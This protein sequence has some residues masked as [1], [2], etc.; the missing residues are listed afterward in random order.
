MVK[1]IIIDKIIGFISGVDDYFIK[2]VDLVEFKFWVVVFLCWVKINSVCQIIIGQIIFNE[3]NFILIINGYFIILVKKEFLFFFILF[4]YFNKIFIQ[5]Q[6][7]DQI[8]GID[9][10]LMEDIVKIYVLKVCKLFKDSNDVKIIIICGFGY[11]GE[12]CYD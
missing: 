12:I 11:K 6:L 8:W 4:F 10:D 1:I 3:E 5:V 2:F 9:L 7:F